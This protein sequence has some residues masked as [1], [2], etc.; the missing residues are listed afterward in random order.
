MSSSPPL[1]ERWT[2]VCFCGQQ[3]SEG[4]SDSTA[5]FGLGEFTANEFHLN[6]NSV[7][8][9]STEITLVD[10]SRYNNVGCGESFHMY[11][12]IR[13]KIGIDGTALDTK[14][15]PTATSG[16]SIQIDTDGTQCN[17]PTGTTAYNGTDI[18][19]PKAAHT[20]ECP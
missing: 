14:T 17:A 2:R 10:K 13:M 6:E 3:T 4:P 16:V 11:V 20:A 1:D 18:G 19:T 5:V 15:Y 8:P 9:D 7:T 12:A